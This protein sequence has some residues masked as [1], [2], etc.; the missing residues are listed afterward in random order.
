MIGSFAP[1]SKT[2]RCE[3]ELFLIP[4]MGIYTEGL[5]NLKMTYKYHVSLVLLRTSFSCPPTFIISCS[6]RT[7]LPA[8]DLQKSEGALL[9]DLAC[10]H[11]QIFQSSPLSAIQPLEEDL[12]CLD[13]YLIVM[14]RKVQDG[15]MEYVLGLASEKLWV[16]IPCKT[17]TSCD[18]GQIC[19]PHKDSVF[20]S[21]KVR[22]WTRDGP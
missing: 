16:Q 18:L 21:P 10:L 11:L 19:E 5:V 20:S 6:C 7:R 2:H 14:D 22:R 17:I 12:P 8:H 15:I 9:K 3:Q 1:E 13:S 4:Y